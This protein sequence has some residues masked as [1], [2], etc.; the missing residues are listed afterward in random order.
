MGGG[1]LRYESRQKGRK[2]EAGIG[3]RE[4]KLLSGVGAS[5]WGGDEEERKKEKEWVSEW[6]V[7]PGQSEWCTVDICYLVSEWS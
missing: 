4:T 5:P 3:S 6:Q 1:I 2:L 7:L